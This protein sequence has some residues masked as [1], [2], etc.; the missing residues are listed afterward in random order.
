MLTFLQM[1]NELKYGALLNL[2]VLLPVV[3]VAGCDT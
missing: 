2:K 3:C 1:Q